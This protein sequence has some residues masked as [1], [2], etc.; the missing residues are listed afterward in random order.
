MVVTFQT[1]DWFLARISTAAVDRWKLHLINSAMNQRLLVLA[2]SAESLLLKNMAELLQGG[3]H[4]HTDH[5]DLYR[6]PNTCI[7]SN[8][9][10]CF[11][12]PTKR[13]RFVELNCGRPSH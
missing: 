3:I 12:R 6:I 9:L 4:H 11:T 7:R 2:P 5:N 13:L 1:R 8:V 10:A